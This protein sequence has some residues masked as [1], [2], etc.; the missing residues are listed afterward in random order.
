MG[1]R[2][3]RVS[4]RAATGGACSANRG[5]RATTARWG[6][7]LA[8]LCFTGLA[9]AQQPTSR[10]DCE[11]SYKPSSGQSGK[12]V[13]WVPTPNTVV[14]RMLTMAKVTPDDTVVDLGAGDGKIAI[15]A[16]KL[17]A[18]ALGIEYNP[19]MVKLATCLAQVEGVPGK[20]RIIQGDIFKEDFSKANV[21]T[22]YLLPELN[23]CVRHRILAMR[24][25]TRVT[26][27]QFNMREWEPDETADVESRDVHL[28]I[29]PARVAGTWTLRNP[30]KPDGLDARVN[31]VQSFQKIGGEIIQGR[32]RH[33]LLGAT[34]RGE[35]IR[36]SFNDE[37]GVTHRFTGKV[38][39]QQLSGYLFSTEGGEAEVTGAMQ[40][41]ARAGNWAAM[42]P[43]CSRFYSQ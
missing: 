13:I 39:G 6:A 34:L 33:P 17:G 20:T 18:N 27:H 2:A 8:A 26:A 40:S 35:D 16:G 15:A 22:M 30:G 37:K 11:R 3:F 21:L 43:Q 38:N 7:A 23:L 5:M 28:W 24:P 42:V 9:A 4:T 14:D 41:Q 36:F 25:G 32:Q 12:D 10:D 1:L 31:L 29:V 19:D